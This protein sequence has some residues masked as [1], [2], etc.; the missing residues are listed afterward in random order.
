MSHHLGIEPPTSQKIEN[1]TARTWYHIV[2]K[3]NLSDSNRV[4]VVREARG[5]PEPAQQGKGFVLYE[6]S[7]RVELR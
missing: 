4:V 1:L 2:I 7:G 6:S 3:E 5:N